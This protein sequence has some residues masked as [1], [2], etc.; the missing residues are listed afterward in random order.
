M[1]VEHGGQMLMPV[2]L[3]TALA[4]GVR[5]CVTTGIAMVAVVMT[6]AGHGC[7][8]LDIWPTPATFYAM[9]CVSLD[10]EYETAQTLIRIAGVLDIVICIGIFIPAFRRPCAMYA[11]VWGFLT[12]IARPV[13]G[14]S[15]SLNFWGA[16]QF[17]HESVLRTPHFLIPL[18]L[19]LMWRKPQTASNSIDKETI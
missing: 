2:L 14:L 11:V 4:W 18:Y 17:L 3:V 13:A 16:D 9:T 8:A 10:V 19:F 12:A 6:F 7:Y 1:F 15:W 5:Q